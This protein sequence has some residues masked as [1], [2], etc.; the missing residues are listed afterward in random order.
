M[1]ESGK[2]TPGQAGFLMIF[3]VLGTSNL[4][5]PVL[6]S[7]YAQMDAWMTVILASLPHVLLIFVMNGI[8]KN[9]PQESIVSYLKKITGKYL[10]ILIILGYLW[11]MIF[12]LTMINRTVSEFLLTSF[13]PETPIEV[14]I[15]VMLLLGAWV[16]KAGLEV[17]ARV[18]TF[19]MP[20]FLISFALIFLLLVGEFNFSY[21]TPVFEYGSKPVIR[22]AIYH[23]LW[24]GE[25]V[26]MLFLW[27][28]LNTPEQGLRSLLQSAVIIVLVML[29]IT[30]ASI[31]VFGPLTPHM[32]FPTFALVEYIELVGFIT[33]I[34][35]VF[36]AVWIAGAFVKIGIFYYCICLT[37]GEVLG[38][39]DYRYI[40]YPV[41]IIC[42]ALTIFIA[43]N[44]AVF[45]NLF[46]TV[47]IPMN[48]LFQYLMPLL[49]LGLIY[50]RGLHK[51]KRGEGDGV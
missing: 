7:R 26:L 28:Y 3:T 17:L 51:E 5:M 46:P 21:L 37:L 1:L 12:T 18:A 39:K 36:M 19:I 44:V 40:V 42:G 15:I 33:R 14:F 35:A 27:P 2:I 23:T 31:A 24:R 30:T 47:L 41:G 50:L 16:T 10:G 45:E 48:L 8:R 25:Y 38:L 49:I 20:L 11:Y 4:V 22:G 34:D 9:F 43:P 13:M 6:T 32:Y 29:P